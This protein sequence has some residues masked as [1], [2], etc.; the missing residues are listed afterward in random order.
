MY[1]FVTLQS[2]MDSMSY[3]TV[4]AKLEAALVTGILDSMLDIAKICQLSLV[5]R[6]IYIQNGHNGSPNK[7]AVKQ[8][9]P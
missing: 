7:P 1:G 2:L 3:R 8:C 5:I 4:V 9:V 6:H